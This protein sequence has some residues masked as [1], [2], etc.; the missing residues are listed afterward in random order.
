MVCDIPRAKNSEQDESR[1]RRLSQ[2]N[3]RVGVVAT[4]EGELS[5]VSPLASSSLAT[6]S[7][8]QSQ[9]I[10]QSIKNLQK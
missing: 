9:S 1:N 7:R 10:K 3:V 2:L 6:P 8:C 5:S 4:E